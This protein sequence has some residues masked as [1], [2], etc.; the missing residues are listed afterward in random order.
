MQAAI[1]GQFDVMISRSGGIAAHIDSMQTGTLTPASPFIHFDQWN[2]IGISWGDQGVKI[3]ANGKSIDSS[4]VAVSHYLTYFGSINFGYWTN[5]NDIRRMK[6]AMKN[7]RFS[8]K[9]NDFTFSSKSPWL[10]A[11]TGFVQKTICNGQSL[12]GYDKPGKYVVTSAKTAEG[13]DSL[14]VLDLKIAPN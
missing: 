12:D 3:M 7:I 4:A 2:V 8:F 5:Q 10:G 11:D 1:P 6:G 9:E 14:Y 13:C